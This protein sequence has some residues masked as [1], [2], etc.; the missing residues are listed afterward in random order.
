MNPGLV[1]EMLDQLLRSLKGSN[2]IKHPNNMFSKSSITA[3][4][5][6]LTTSLIR[7]NSEFNQ[8]RYSFYHSLSWTQYSLL[9]DW[10]RSSYSLYRLVQSIKLWT[11]EI[12]SI[13]VISTSEHNYKRNCSHY[14]DPH[15][16]HVFI[17]YCQSANLQYL[18]HS[19]AQ[20]TQITITRINYILYLSHGS[21]KQSHISLTR[22][23]TNASYT[24]ILH[25]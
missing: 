16:T 12:V 21:L 22:T 20:T 13:S 17:L 4:T 3:L 23:I 11:L 19:I 18:T 15:T 8:R 1:G 6:N 24:D 7:T 10:V 14:Y 25:R 9:T 5:K 2:P